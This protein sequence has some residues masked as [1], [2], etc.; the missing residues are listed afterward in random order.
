M[1]SETPGKRVAGTGLDEWLETNLPPSKRAVGEREQK[2]SDMIAVH[3][4][5][6]RGW[7]ERAKSAQVALDL[8]KDPEDVAIRA[9]Q[10]QDLAEDIWQFLN[11]WEEQNGR[12][13]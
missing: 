2:P 8:S 1:A 10:L 6:L 12:I 9:G 3:A 13:R 4:T 5:R 11:N 7:A